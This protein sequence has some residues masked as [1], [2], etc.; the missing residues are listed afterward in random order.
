MRELPS[1]PEGE[2]GAPRDDSRATGA[3]L[4]EP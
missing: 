4:G 1:P 2:G 3:G